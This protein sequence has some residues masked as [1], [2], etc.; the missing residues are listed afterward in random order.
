ML[1]PTTTTFTGIGEATLERVLEVE[2]DDPNVIDVSWFHGFPYTDI[3]MVGTH[4]AV[5]TRGE[6]I[7][8][9]T[10][11]GRTTAWVPLVQR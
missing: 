1:L 6:P 2:K 3:P 11:G 9:V 7:V 10:I 4:I 5:T 8:H